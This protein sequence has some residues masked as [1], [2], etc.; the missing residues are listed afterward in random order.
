M[1]RVASSSKLAR[2]VWLGV[3]FA[4]LLTQPTTARAENWPGWRGGGGG[5]DGS[6]ISTEKGL[7]VEWDAKTNIVWKVAVPGEGNSS[8]IVWDGRT[9]LTSALEVGKKRLVLCYDATDGHELWRRE[10]AVATP[11]PTYP[12]NG[13]ASQTPVTD[14]QRIYAFF[15]EPGLIALDAKTGTIDWQLP[16]GPFKT[17]GYLA[18]S[19]I[20]AG[21]LVVMVCDVNESTVAG[22]R[23]KG[24][25]IVAVDKASGRQFWRTARKPAAH[26]A[27]PL[28]I[29]ADGRTQIVV[30]GDPVIAYDALTGQEVWSCQGMKPMCAPSPV[31][32]DG[33]V[34]VTSG[35]N[36]PAMAIDP[37]G[38]GDVSETHGTML[39]DTGGPYVP[40]PL[41]YPCLM[42]PGDDGQISFLDKSGQ[43]VLRTR[44][45]GH[46]SASPM[47]A[48]GRIYWS[49]EKGRTYVLDARQL[50]AREPRAPLIANNDLGE[51]ILA[52]P[53][54]SNGRLYLRSIA[55]LYCIAG[56]ARTRATVAAATAQPQAALIELTQQLKKSP[57]NEGPDIVIRLAVVEALATLK[58][59]GANAVLLTIAQKDPHWD[60]SEA[61]AKALASRGPEATVALLQML[62]DG[63]EYPAIIAAEALGE[64]QA[65]PASAKLATRAR[66]KNQFVR[67]AALRALGRI[68]LTPDADPEVILPALIAG[69]SQD[70]EG[71]VKMAAIQAL[72]GLSEK[73]AA[74]RAEIVLRLK[75]CATDRN[76]RVAKAASEA[77]VKDYPVPPTS[78]SQPA[79]K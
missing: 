26:A 69:L 8:P 22:R 61:A 56:S 29:V 16:L 76:I 63:R 2:F 59:P 64:L 27:T 5:G 75:V 47:A 62:D 34:W 65:V 37:T 71:P 36:G 48:E 58:D 46:F 44:V 13:Y 7:P 51:P 49:D 21:E 52:S 72:A 45:P 60:V 32:A 57:A 78:A 33:L 74:H 4:A 79:G 1:V 20:L 28:A 67:L 55:N 14:G 39:T 66:D 25:F 12:K 3:V 53:A 43:L 17:V 70:L 68:A 50:T 23:Q 73:V 42:L 11:A 77:L 31:F 15:D 18:A 19:P 54:T 10:F 30:S 6:G 9:C 35:R 40:S 24:G 38:Q 41:V